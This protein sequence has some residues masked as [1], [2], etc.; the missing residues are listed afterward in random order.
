MAGEFVMIR[1]VVLR[2]CLFCLVLAGCRYR[3]ELPPMAPVTGKV[4]LDG[5]QLPGGMVQFIPDASRGNKGASGVGVIDGQGHYEI[6]TAGERGAILGHHQ[7]AVISEEKV[8]MSETSY[9]PSLIPRR[10]NKPATSGLRVEVKA[11]ENNVVDL[12]LRSQP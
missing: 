8:D 12:E 5:A 4:T 11:G 9:A 2:I 7:I 3:A 6:F 10:Y 1:R